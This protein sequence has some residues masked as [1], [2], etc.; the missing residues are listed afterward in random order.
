[1]PRLLLAATASVD[2]FDRV[3]GE[4]RRFFAE[5]EDRAK[6]ILREAMDRP[7]EVRALLKGAVRPWLGAVAEYIERGKEHEH[8]YDGVDAEAYVVN[9]L[10]L[11]ICTTATASV[12]TAVLDE[13]TAPAR[14][15]TPKTSEA[16]ARLDEELLR[17]ARTSLFK[18]MAAPARRRPR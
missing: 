4:C 14:R 10:L 1:M 16:R 7:A 18:P 17:I 2:R 11:V 12:S 6:L 13:G 3:F 8:H 5:D 15:P 9:I